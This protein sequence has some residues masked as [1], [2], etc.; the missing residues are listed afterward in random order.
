[1]FSVYA[2]IGNSD[3]I[4]IETLVYGNSAFVTNADQL[5][6]HLRSPLPRILSFTFS[7]VALPLRYAVRSAINS[8]LKLRTNKMNRNRLKSQQFNRFFF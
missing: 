8:K 4:T 1:M 6:V 3:H 5:R 2:N 7:P